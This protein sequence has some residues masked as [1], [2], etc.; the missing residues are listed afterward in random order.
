[1]ALVA[2][3]ECGKEIS[4]KAPACPH[5]GAPLTT[6]QSTSPVSAL[7]P[8]VA[9]NGGA[10]KWIVGVPVG[11]FVLFI[12]YGMMLNSSPEG[13]AKADAR[14]A[15]ELCWKEQG[16]K[17]LDPGSQ[18]FVAGACEMMEKQFRQTYNANP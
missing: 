2:C 5:C 14:G 15:I 11:L 9:K 1:M 7:P 4:D 18:R 3:K 8:E 13:K 6:W 17:S 10:W 12:A 16:R